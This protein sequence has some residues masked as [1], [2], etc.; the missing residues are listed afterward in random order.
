MS[1]MEKGEKQKLKT[2]FNPRSIAIIGASADEKKLGNIVVRN[3]DKFGY[4]GEIYLVNPHLPDVSGH[5]VFASYS[6]IPVVPDLAIITTPAPTISA[7]L[8]EVGEKGTKLGLVFA[9]GFKE[10]GE[11]GEKLEKELI[12]VANKFQMKVL[13]P[14]CLGYTSVAAGVNATFGIVAKEE[15]NLRFVSQS[16]AVATSLFDWAATHSVGFDHFVTIGNKSVLN[17]NDFLE[18]WLSNGFN[19]TQAAKFQKNGLSKLQPIGMYL[20]SV[21]NGKKFA[22]L[23]SLNST[24]NPVIV[25]KPGKSKAASSAMLSHTGALA[26]D[27]KVFSAALEMSSAIRAEGIEDMFDLLK[28]FSWE[29]APIGPRTAI[30]SNAG[31]PAV[32]TTDFISES[33]LELAPLSKKTIDKLGKLLPREAAF[34]NPIDVL[35]DAGS[36]RYHSALEI[37]LKDEKVDSVLVLLTPQIMTEIEETAKIICKM[38]SRY[39]KTII[40]SFMGGSQTEAGIKILN[41]AKIPSF[42]YP[43]RAVRVL[44]KMW[45]WN[46]KNRKYYG[47]EYKSNGKLISDSSLGRINSFIEKISAKRKMLSSYEVNEIL[48]EIGVRLPPYSLVNSFADA[49]EFAHRYEYPIAVKITSPAVVHKTDIGGVYS[50]ITDSDSLAI[51]VRKLQKIVQDIN[52]KKK[53]AGIMA[54]KFVPSGVEVI[55]GIKKDPN[56]GRILLVGTGGIYAELFGDSKIIVLPADKDAIQGLL[57]NSKL[58]KILGGYRTGKPYAVEKFIRLIM[59]LDGLLERCASLKEIEINPVI[60]TQDD[61]YAVDGRAFI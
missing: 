24:R 18:Y 44:G 2:L 30:V 20:E 27:D 29:N 8:Q 47:A 42:R 59:L 45:E 3:L 6:Q 28:A 21:S 31:G 17:E 57:L 1:D 38:S 13:G 55:V 19:K 36:D 7:L 50:K 35:G 9:A 46:N 48:N 33:G 4:K 16:G 39:N 54:Q 5:R 43:E 53:D 14:N 10:V 60:I 26:G 15:G 37:V 11:D 52:A 12:D 32:I 58:G 22:E 40:C 49:Q 56:F 41:E 61:I 51:A 25:L 23:V 34:H